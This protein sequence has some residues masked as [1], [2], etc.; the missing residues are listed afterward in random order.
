SKPEAWST[1][2]SARRSRPRA[3]T[4]TSPGSG[5]GTRRV[6]GRPPRGRTG[7]RARA[8]AGHIALSGGV[9]VLGRGVQLAL[10]GVVKAVAVDDALR[11]LSG[12]GFVSA[13]GGPAT[14][15]G[16]GVALARRG[17]GRGGSGPG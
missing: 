12:P 2:P 5:R 15:G 7:A 14:P 11:L 13:G 6:A 4:G 10:N 1:R 17:A 8:A 16:G 9:L 3:Q